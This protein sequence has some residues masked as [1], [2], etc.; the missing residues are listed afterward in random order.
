MSVSAFCRERRVCRKSFY[1]WRKELRPE[2]EALGEAE[3]GFAEVVRVAGGGDRAWSGVSV[4]LGWP[5]AIRVERGFDAASNQQSNQHPIQRH[6]P[7]LRPGKLG[8][9]QFIVNPTPR[10]AAAGWH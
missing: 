10:A 8:L 9:E 5:P 1:A 2:A 7:A 3:E 6:D 4:V